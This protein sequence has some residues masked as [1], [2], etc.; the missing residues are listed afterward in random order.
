M[1]VQ[2]FEWDPPKERINI[3]KHGIGFELAESVFDDPYLLLEEDRVVDDE[4][5]LRAI[6]LA[7][8]KL[9]LLV[10]HTVRYED[11]KETVIRIITV[12]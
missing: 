3:R 5:R 7:G 1:S 9:L 10:I 11:S 2:R 4:E 12:W 8:G 6:G